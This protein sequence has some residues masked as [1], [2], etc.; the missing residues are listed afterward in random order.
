MDGKTIIGVSILEQQEANNR[1]RI[2]QEGRILGKEYLINEQSDTINKQHN[3]IL[4][5]QREANS[6]QP[7]TNQQKI[8]Q[9]EVEELKNYK[10]LLSKPMEEI[11]RQNGAFKETYMKQQE[12]L[13]QWMLSQRAFKEIAMQ[14][15]QKL[16]K[17]PEQVVAEGEATKE[18]VKN[19]TTQFNNGLGQK[20]LDDLNYA[21]NEE[22]HRASVMKETEENI[23]R[24]L[25]KRALECK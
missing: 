7:L 11:A 22:S 23:K 6:P 2:D 18:A 13:A 8:L 12:L 24:R 3:Q 10:E 5:L 1:A 15:G 19:N 14:Y 16:G 4:A 17:T 20:E 9:E 21:E 25:E